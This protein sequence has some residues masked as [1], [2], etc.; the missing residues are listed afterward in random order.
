MPTS[1]GAKIHVNVYRV[2]SSWRYATWVEGF[3]FRAAAL[4]V[5]DDAP[6]AAAIEAAH[7]LYTDRVTVKR[8]PDLQCDGAERTQRRPAKRRD[9]CATTPATATG[10]SDAES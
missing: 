3:L 8:M 4:Q 9:R 2:R 7:A 1:P 5:D 6:E 10:S